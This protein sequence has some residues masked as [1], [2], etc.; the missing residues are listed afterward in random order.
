M[1][2]IMIIIAAV[3]AVFAGYL[4]FA[5]R[6]MKNKNTKSLFNFCPIMSNFELVMLAVTGAM[7]KTKYF[8]SFLH[9]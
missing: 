4:Y 8:I 9:G 2:T 3:A 1:S 7:N 5:Y 6:K